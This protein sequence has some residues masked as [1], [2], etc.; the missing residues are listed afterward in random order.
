MKSEYFEFSTDI[1]ELYAIFYL[2]NGR[3]RA[4]MVFV[5]KSAS[6]LSIASFCTSVLP[7]EGGKGVSF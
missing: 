2:T 1:F 4:I 7:P 5:L 6:R 3:T